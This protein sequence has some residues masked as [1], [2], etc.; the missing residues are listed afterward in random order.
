MKPPVWPTRKKAPEKAL[1]CVRGTGYKGNG[2]LRCSFDEEFNPFC[3]LMR[4][5]RGGGNPETFCYFGF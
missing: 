2:S 4:A 1:F 5:V 3:L